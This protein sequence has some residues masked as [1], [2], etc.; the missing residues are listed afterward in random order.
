MKQCHGTVS[1]TDQTAS[2]GSSHRRRYLRRNSCH[3]RLDSCTGLGDNGLGRKIVTPCAGRHSGDSPSY[4]PFYFV[5]STDR[6]TGDGRLL[7][8]CHVLGYACRVAV[9]YSRQIVAGEVATTVDTKPL[10][11]GSSLSPAVS[12]AQ[13]NYAPSPKPSINW[14]L[15]QLRYIILKPEPPIPPSIVRESARILNSALDSVGIFKKTRALLQSFQRGRGRARVFP[16][17]WATEIKLSPILFHVFLFL[18]LFNF[19][20]LLKIVEKS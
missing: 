10:S 5:A 8:V 13:P 20:N 14:R 17:T 7:V 19:R 16:W 12:T 11:Q 9:T 3:R 2:A 1:E 15:G 6:F 4:L 18:F